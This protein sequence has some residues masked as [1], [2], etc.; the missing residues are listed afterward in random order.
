MDFYIL[1]LH[2]IFCILYFRMRKINYN[3]NIVYKKMNIN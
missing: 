2:S 3:E 1:Y